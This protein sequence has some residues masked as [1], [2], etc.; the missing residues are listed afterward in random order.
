MKHHRVTGTIHAAKGDTLF[1]MATE[2]SRNDPNYRL[3]W[4]KGQLVVILSRT[5]FAKNTIFVGDKDDTIAAL[6]DLLIHK[7]Q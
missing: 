3:W 4:D 1:S 2:I 5:K 6:K 7:T